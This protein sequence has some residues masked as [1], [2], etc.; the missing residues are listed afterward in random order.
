MFVRLRVWVQYLPVDAD[1]WMVPANESCTVGPCQRQSSGRHRQV[2]E[3]EA[4][5][6][7]RSSGLR[8]AVGIRN[9]R[10]FSCV[11]HRWDKMLFG[12]FGNICFW[13]IYVRTCEDQLAEVDHSAS[14]SA[15]KNQVVGLIAAVAYL[16]A[17]LVVLNILTCVFEVLLG[18]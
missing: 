10:L 3:T 4:G 1:I 18:G 13:Y 16:R 7:W 17:P 14:A 6:V 5:H 9:Q 2:Y 15:M 8:R 12:T 11:G